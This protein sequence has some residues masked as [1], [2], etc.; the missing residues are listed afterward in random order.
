MQAWKL[1]TRNARNITRSQRRGHF[2]WRQLHGIDIE[3]VVSG[4]VT[5]ERGVLLVKGIFNESSNHPMRPPACRYLED[6]SGE[7]MSMMPPWILVYAFIDSSHPSVPLRSAQ[8]RL[9]DVGVIEDAL[10]TLQHG[11][12]DRGGASGPS[13]KNCVQLFRLLQL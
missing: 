8:V 13:I 7:G 11:T 6:I 4:Q 9:T 5:M 1:Q 3:S 12:L 2:D 10:D